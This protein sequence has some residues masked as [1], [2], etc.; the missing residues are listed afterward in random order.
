MKKILIVSFY[1]LKEYFASVKERFEE[2]LFTVLNYPLFRYCYDANDKLEN[3]KE[4]LN[5]YIQDNNPDIILWWFIDVPVDIFRFIKINNPNV[6]YIMY[7]ADDPINMNKEL[8]DKAKIFDLVVTPCKE[9]VYMYKL[10]SNVKT[11]IFNPSGF[12]DML[13][14]PLH[15]PNFAVKEKDPKQ[16]YNHYKSDISMLFYNLFLDKSTFP[17]QVIYKKTLIDN[18]IDYCKKNEYIFKIYGAPV[19]NEYFP[20]NYCGS[21]PYH[22]INVLYNMSKINIVSSPWK[23]K[24]LN[25]SEYVFPILGSGSLLMIDKIRDIESLFGDNETCIIYDSDNYLDK[26]G[27]ILSNYDSYDVIKHEG[28]ILSKKYTWKNWVNNIVIEYGKSHFDS[29]LYQNIYDLKLLNLS[30]EQLLERW[31]KEGMNKKEICYNFS[32]PDNF[33]SELYINDKN[34]KNDKM[35]SYIHWRIYSNSATYMKK[36]RNSANNIFPTTM[37]NV[38]MEDYYDACSILNRVIKYNTRDKGLI[39]LNQFCSE[40]I[41][42]NI[43]EIVTLYVDNVL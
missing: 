20:N 11:V 6:Y 26:I 41:N 8:L 40:S 25:I 15:D 43:N 27:S 12:D 35:F 37:S 14:K 24:S 38:S 34:V 7:N 16:K 21:V 22:E 5:E 42:L 29:D 32:V 2:L 3:Y 30:K 33:N 19:L 28:H 13:F 36:K 9:S 39:E 18:L 17:N 4:H 31:I 1:E 10:Y 23:N